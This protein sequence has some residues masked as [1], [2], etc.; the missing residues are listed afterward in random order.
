MMVQ[1][2][3]TWAYKTGDQC[4]LLPHTRLVYDL[5]DRTLLCYT[6][7]WP[8]DA[9]IAIAD[10]TAL[11]LTIALGFHSRTI[12]LQ[13]HQSQLQLSVY[14]WRQFNQTLTMFNRF[15]AEVGPVT[16]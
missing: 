15:G 1:H 5:T 10:V 12:C 4:Q 11:V 2:T 16:L 14:T 6:V 13:R 9:G 3:K 8:T 7:V